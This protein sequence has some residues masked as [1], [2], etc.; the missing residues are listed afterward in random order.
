MMEKLSESVALI[1]SIIAV[2]SSFIG[3]FKNYSNKKEEE[4]YEKIVKPFLLQSRC[5]F[6]KK[7]VDWLKEN[8]KREDEYIPMYVHYALE[9]EKEE[10]V[11]KVIY[12]D[13]IELYKNENFTKKK[14]LEAVSRVLHYIT[15]FLIIFLSV[16]SVIFLFVGAVVL[17][18]WG[19][20]EIFSNISF[21]VSLMDLLKIEIMGVVGFL[22]AIL[23]NCLNNRI[24]PDRYVL[25]KESLKKVLCSKKRKYNKNSRDM[26]V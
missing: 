14:I 24:Y 26:Y 7:A 23:L 11:Y 8:V 1:S 2:L 3:M 13:Y 19:L 12:T 10:D 9:N 21:G 18:W 17:I 4:Y 5:G 16:F 22:Y 20:S 15:M 6:N 25:K